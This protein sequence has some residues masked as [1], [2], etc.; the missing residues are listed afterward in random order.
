MDKIPRCT[1]AVFFI[2]VGSVQ[3][4]PTSQRP[5]KAAIIPG[6]AEKRQLD[7]HGNPSPT[8]THHTSH[9]IEFCEDWVLNDAGEWKDHVHRCNLAATE[10]KD[11]IG[12]RAVVCGKVAGTRYASRSKAQPTFLNLDQ[13]YPKQVFAIVIWGSNRPK[14]GEPESTYQDKKVCVTGKITN[15]R[16]VPEIAASDPGQIEIQK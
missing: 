7:K 1:F 11:H 16:G 14:F 10:A 4:K 15:Y 8:P 5:S 3:C 2:L 12:E 13:P 9:G 6:I